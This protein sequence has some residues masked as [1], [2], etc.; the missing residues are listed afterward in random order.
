VSG[1]LYGRNPD[2]LSFA[3]TIELGE[4]TELIDTD[5]ALLER[6]GPLKVTAKR[7][8]FAPGSTSV[9]GVT[10]SGA[11]S[12][13]LAFEQQGSAIRASGRITDLDVGRLV[14]LGGV[15]SPLKAARATLDVRYE[16][17]RAGTSGFVV[18]WLEDVAYADVK[19]ARADIDLRLA[20]ERLTGTVMAALA[21]GARVVLS[22]DDLAVPGPPFELPPPD[23][24]FGRVALRG[25]FDLHGMTPLLVTFPEV[26]IGDARGRVAADVVYERRPEAA[27]SFVASVRTNGL[28]LS[29]RLTRREPILTTD[30]AI[31][32]STWHLD[33]VDVKLD[34]ALDAAARKLVV[35]GVGFDEH[36]EL[37]RVEAS[38]SEL[39]ALPALSALATAWQDIPVQAKVYVPERRLRRLPEPVRPTATNGTVELSAAL[40]GTARNPRMSVSGK[41]GRLRAAGGREL[42]ER[43]ERID[44][45]FSASYARTGGKLL[46]YARNQEQPAAELAGKWEGDLLKFDPEND[47]ELLLQAEARLDKLQLDTISALKNRQIGGELSG[48]VVLEYGKGRRRLFVDARA[49]KLELGQVKLDAVSAGVLARD[50]ELRGDVTVRGQAGSLDAAIRSGLRWQ[51]RVAPEPQGDIDANLDARGFR[52]GALWPL[53]S[54]SFSELDGRL[55]AKLAARVRD[56]K[57]ALSGKGALAEGV[58][59]IPALG[60]RFDRIRA[61][62]D[63]MPEEIRLAD[64]R[65]HGVSGALS[66][67]SVI[68]LDEQLKLR[69]VRGAVRIKEAERIPVTL[70]GVTIG[71][72]W[73]NIDARYTVKPDHNAVDVK[74]SGMH[75]VVPDVDQ[76]SV[77]SLEPAEGVRIGVH[78]KDQKFVAL[79]IQPLEQGT[80]GREITPTT[81]DI[82]LGKDFWVK[83]GDLVNVQLTGKLQARAAEETTLVGRI[84]VAGGTLDVS[85]KRFEIERGTIA[86]NGGDPANPTVTALARWDSPAGYTV[87]AEYAGTAENGHLKLRAEP[88]LSEDQIVTLLMFGTPDGSYAGSSSGGSGD[89]AAGAIG[90]AG[91]TAARGLNRALSSMTKLDVQARVDTSTGSARPEIVVGLSPRLSARVTRAIGEP[92]AGTSPDRT[93]LTLELRLQRNWVLSGLV[94]DRGA[95]ALD[96]IWRHRY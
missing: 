90:I 67:S 2:E 23:R 20:A 74:F 79:P 64:V 55:D 17:G 44:V 13:A 9:E 1:R 40:E 75:L 52:L 48:D 54:A 87:Y 16:S 73:G 29:G 58:V 7:L 60:Q 45:D 21:P 53:T 76:H 46:V 77:Q 68:L 19:G 95:S 5:L 41:F 85:G 61:R 94:G 83:R 22:V 28:D 62:I 33:E 91:G 32:A 12:A 11:G 57:L 3:T 88:P 24:V 81:V 36:G 78:Q 31:A 8:S 92:P 47:R 6:E 80:A 34:V 56:G 63:V 37:V 59:Q 89:T 72:A 86:F 96:L 25:N 15:K 4:R 10:I 39:P 42:G 70:E 26:P 69:E 65:A 50:G 30:E 66:A 43:P 71:D 49:A 82:D 27:P 35:D 51:G 14:R 18:G 38:A 93:F 84:Q